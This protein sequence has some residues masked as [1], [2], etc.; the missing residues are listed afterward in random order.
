MI[1]II[2]GFILGFVISWIAK[3]KFN[4]KKTEPS[5]DTDTAIKYLTEKGYKIRLY[6]GGESK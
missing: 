2:V 6:N 5:L 4:N 1:E 3:N